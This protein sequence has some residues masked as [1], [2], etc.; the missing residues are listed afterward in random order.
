MSGVQREEVPQ[1]SS[2]QGVS[3]QVDDPWVYRIWKLTSRVKGL[4][5]H[6]ICGVRVGFGVEGFN[7]VAKADDPSANYLSCL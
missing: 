4:K 5:L 1:R 6:G 3:I 7:L 2:H